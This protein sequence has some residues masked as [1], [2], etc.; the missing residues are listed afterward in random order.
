MEV[1]P[2][3][4]ASSTA[5]LTTPAPSP[6]PGCWR[7]PW[8]SGSGSSRPPISSSTWASGLARPIRGRR[9]LTLVHAMLAVGLHRRRRPAALWR[10]QPGAGPPGHGALHLGTFLR[11]VT[12]GHVRQLDRLAEQLLARAWAAWAGPGDG[13]MTVDLDSTVCQVRGYHRQGAAYGYTHTLGYHPLVASRADSGQVLP[14]SSRSLGHLWLLMPA[15]LGP[16]G[17]RLRLLAPATAASRAAAARRPGRSP[18]R[19]DP[20]RSAPRR[21][22]R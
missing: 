3:P 4:G 1:L 12:F 22:P 10:H 2:T 8:P 9:L 16:H 17:W 5:A 20:R 11:A 7:P 6:M 18:L 13:P 19:A 14:A 15:S 21:S